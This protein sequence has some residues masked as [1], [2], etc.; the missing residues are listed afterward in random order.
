MAWVE[1]VLAFLVFFAS[2]S[3]LIRPPVKP[4][5]VAR[6]GSRGFTAFYVILSLAV[7]AWLINA[8]GQA[9]YVELWPWAPWQSH[10]TLALMLPACLL[11]AMS[12]ARPNPF[13][14]G[15]A[16]NDRFDPEHPGIIRWTRHPLLAVLALWAMAHLLPNGDLAHA[17]VFGSFA[18]FALFGIRLVDQRKRLELGDEWQRLLTRV[19]ASRVIPK[20]VYYRALVFRL[21]VGIGLFYALIW[22]HPL[23]LGVSLV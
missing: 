21:S 22:L 7:L 12:I 6:I 3:I 11:L 14:F 19:Q 2:H 18:A 10:V 20:P 9:P 16:L 4:W 8:A 17:L 1:F 23:I 13:S 15:G 5:L